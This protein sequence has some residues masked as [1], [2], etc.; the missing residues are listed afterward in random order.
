MKKA[1]VI[2]AAGLFVLACN[3]TGGGGDEPQPQQE[4][5]AVNLNLSVNWG[6]ANLSSK[7]AAAYYAWGEVSPRSSADIWSYTH[8]SGNKCLKYNSDV[9]YSVWDKLKKLENQD[10]A[11]RAALGAGWHIP[12]VD[13]WNELLTCCKWEWVSGANPGYKVTSKFNGASI[14]LPAEGFV[15]G[16]ELKSNG[17]CGYYWSASIPQVCPI[18]A[19]ALSFDSDSA[20]TN[21]LIPRVFG[22]SIRPVK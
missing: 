6:S 18:Y 12:T 22:L 16:S 10:D 13:E 7:G 8:W 4:I 21:S 3:G 1:L 17:L 9:N 14:F 2:L 5:E 19:T 20:S 15:A 11:A